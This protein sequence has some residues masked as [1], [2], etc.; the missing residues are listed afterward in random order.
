MA[1]QQS[2]KNLHPKRFDIPILL[3]LSGVLLVVGLSKPVI[4][5][6][7]LWNSNTQS[8]ISSIDNLWHEKDYVLAVIIFFFSII[9]PIV[10]LISLSI[11]WF[12]RLEDN[13]RKHL[14]QMMEIL[15]R[16]SMLDVFVC[17]VVIVTVKLGV[18]AKARMEIGIYYFAASIFLAM[19]VSTMQGYLVRK[20]SS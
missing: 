15:G 8:I 9:F 11:I 19:T 16:W 13:D 6:K 10:K 12:M 17:A 7:K 1:K 14:V 4:T 3:F 2:L 5:V 20:H 18:L